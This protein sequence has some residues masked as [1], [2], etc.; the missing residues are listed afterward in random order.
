MGSEQD[1]AS[2]TKVLGS[3]EDITKLNIYQRLARIRAEVQTVEKSGKH[4]HFAYAKHDD[5]TATLA[6][7]YLKYGVDREVSIDDV[8]R[9]NE[10][11]LVK[12]TMSWVNVDNPSDRKTVG[13]SA[14][15]VDIKQNDGL[16]SGKA[17][18]YAV[19]ISELKN[20]CLIGE[21]TP[22][23]ERAQIGVSAS[24][25]PPSTA[26]YSKLKELYQACGTEEELKTIRGM[27]MPM[28]QGKALDQAQISELSKLDHEAKGRIK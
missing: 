17:L 5:V 14:E 8:A 9:S 12:G 13:I 19:K 4:K 7:L 20:F 10:A 28:V 1:S 21:P 18:S 2:T 23:N 3:P 16:A 11:F 6:P 15:G 25:V 22:D 27:V 24:F 26:E